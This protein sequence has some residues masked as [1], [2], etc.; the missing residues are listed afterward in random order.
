MPIFRYF[1]VVGSALLGLFFATDYMWGPKTAPQSK[2]AATSAP[3]SPVKIVSAIST[4]DL[5]LEAPPVKPVIA[6]EDLS[7]VT[8]GQSAAATPKSVAA[9]EPP[10]QIARAAPARKQKAKTKVAA[11]R[12]P[13]DRYDRSYRA[14]YPPPSYY[15]GGWN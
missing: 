7:A 9:T 4:R 14:E 10:K 11:Q 8:T 5:R 2:V 12:P 3:A 15:F 13:W 1:V 6:A